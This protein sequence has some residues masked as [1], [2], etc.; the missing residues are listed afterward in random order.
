MEG[1]VGVFNSR[2]DATKALGELRHKINADK[3]IFLTPESSPED[4]AE[5]PT[6]EAERPGVGEAITSVVGAAIGSGAGLGLGTAAA[7]L[8]VPGVG[9]IFAIGLGAAAVLGLTGAAIGAKV[10]KDE[11]AFLDNGVPRDDIGCYRRLLKD[12]KSIVIAETGDGGL[13][14]DLRD[15]MKRNGGR[16]FEDVRKELLGGCEEAA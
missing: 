11:E 9:P 5:V 13:I 3:V 4:I 2:A 12:G 10:G 15:I 14:D 16:P 7:S 1:V 6:T 8:V